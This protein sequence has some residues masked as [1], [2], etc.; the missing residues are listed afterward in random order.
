M[1]GCDVCM[2]TYNFQ[3]QIENIREEAIKIGYKPTTISK[4]MSIWRTFIKWK[5]ENNFIYN[6][7]EYS[8]FLLEHYKFDII[9]Y[10]HNSKS[11]DQQLMRSKKILD[12]FNT[13]KNFIKKRVVPIMDETIELLNQYLKDNNINYGKIFKVS[14]KIIPLLKI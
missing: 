7:D 10:T 13:Y 4:Y 6:Q 5:K 3:E 1:K 12:D 11:R 9:T 2:K 8:T 14:E